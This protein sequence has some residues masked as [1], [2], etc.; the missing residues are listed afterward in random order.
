MSLLPVALALFWHWSMLSSSYIHLPDHLVCNHWSVIICQCYRPPIFTY[1][2]ILSVISRSLLPSVD[3]IHTIWLRPCSHF[4]VI[5]FLHW[6][7]YK[8]SS[9]KYTISDGHVH[10]SDDDEK[11]NEECLLSCPI[12]SQNHTLHDIASRFSWDYRFQ[13]LLLS[14]LGT[15]LFL[16]VGVSE[17][18]ILLLYGKNWERHPWQCI[19]DMRQICPYIW[20][21]S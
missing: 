11:G 7:P 9:Q 10:E 21:L 4:L 3:Y 20:F 6:W 1:S 15:I 17:C 8:V 5:V 19:N 12:S 16:I 2:T 14:L 18:Y 13:E